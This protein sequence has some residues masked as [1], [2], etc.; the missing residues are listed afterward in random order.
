LVLPGVSELPQ[1][2]QDYG[3]EW[4][5]VGW[6]AEEFDWRWL[7]GNATGDDVG[8]HLTYEAEAIDLVIMLACWEA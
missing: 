5:A 6:A 3:G 8:K 2:F 4:T 7:G 1:I